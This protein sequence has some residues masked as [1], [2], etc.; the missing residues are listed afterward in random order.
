MLRILAV[1][2]MYPTPQTPGR[3]TFIEEQIKGL[4]HVGMIVEVIC[5]E[6]KR[7]KGY[8]GLSQRLRSCIADF[9]PQIV[10]VMYGGI[11]AEIATRVVN[12]RPCVVSFCGSDLLGEHLSGPLRK[13]IAGYGVLAS[14]W[15]AS[16]SS[17]IVVKSQ[18]LLQALP[19]YVDRS[20]ARI[21]PN[22]ID[23]QRFRCLDRSRCREKL[24]WSEKRFHIM[25]SDSFR[26]PVKRPELARAA[27]EEVKRFG[28]EAEMHYL[29]GVAHRDVPQWL[30]ASDVLLLT[31]SHEGSPNVVKEALACD[32]PVVSVEVG[33]VRERIMGIEG[34]YL[35]SPQ[36]SELAAKLCLVYAGPRRVS[37]RAKIS[38]LSLERVTLR[39]REFYAEILARKEKQG[40]R[41][42]NRVARHT[43]G[44]KEKCP[45]VL[46]LC[47]NR[48][49]RCCSATAVPA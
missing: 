46:S 49:K 34:C 9:Q 24:G 5:A 8:L 40:P 35:A 15:A 4:R 29:N 26:N 14:R 39:L 6:K 48:R 30:N 41:R 11:I 36:A 22:G 45:L 43:K 3:G 13:L 47:V 18:N 19:S 1:T 23:L 21:I 42:W 17:G 12:D 27:V 33:D 2:N 10:H 44:R 25:F 28:F 38:E 20:K 37:G 32:V 31:S 7:I 16:R